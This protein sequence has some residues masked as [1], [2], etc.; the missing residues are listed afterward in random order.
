MSWLHPR[1]ITFRNKPLKPCTVVPLPSVALLLLL[2]WRRMGGLSLG[3]RFNGDGEAAPGSEP[4]PACTW[5]VAA[6][7][8]P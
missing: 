6:S 4:L 8:L 3:W 1:A 5:A 7:N 2:A